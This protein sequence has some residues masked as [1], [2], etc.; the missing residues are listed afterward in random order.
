M[1]RY[2][3]T[4]VSDSIEDVCSVE[5]AFVGGVNIRSYSEDPCL[6][7]SISDGNN[8]ESDMVAEWTSV[9]ASLR[10]VLHRSI[11]A[12]DIDDVYKQKYPVSLSGLSEKTH[13]ALHKAMEDRVS[14][15]GNVHIEV[16]KGNTACFVISRSTRRVIRIIPKTPCQLCRLAIL[17][18]EESS[19]TLSIT[20]PGVCEVGGRIWGEGGQMKCLSNTVECNIGQFGLLF[21]SSTSEVELCVQTSR[22]KYVMVVLWTE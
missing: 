7:I 2:T 17:N 4:L 1:E 20:T 18:L 16:R 8:M 5:S 3:S 21:V 12:N 10:Y 22:R 14:M 11:Y 9:R 19:I 13:S 15:E 6:Y